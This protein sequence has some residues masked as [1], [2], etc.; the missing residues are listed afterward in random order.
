[1]RKAISTDN[2]LTQVEEKKWATE[3]Q[4]DGF[5]EFYIYYCTQLLS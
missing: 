5:G 3:E 2:R 1:M 4:I